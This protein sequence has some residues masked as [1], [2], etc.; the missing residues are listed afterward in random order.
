M[1]RVVALI[2]LVAA[3][4][5]PVSALMGSILGSETCFRIHLAFGIIFFFAA[6]SHIV[7]NWRTLKFFITGKKS[8]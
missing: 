3:I 2:L 6:I 5:L 1:M 8:E 4:M 7:I